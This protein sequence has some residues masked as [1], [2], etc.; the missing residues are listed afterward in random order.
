MVKEKSYFNSRYKGQH[1]YRVTIVVTFR[2]EKAQT[3]TWLA[4][5]STGRE[6]KKKENIEFDRRLKNN[7][8]D[9]KEYF[10]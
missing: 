9:Y 5:L 7:V 1:G 10:Y 2:K 3:Y 8:L 4:Q 6:H